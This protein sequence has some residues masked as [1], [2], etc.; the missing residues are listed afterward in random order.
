MLRV[1][2]LQWRQRRREA[3]R[4]P[5]ILRKWYKWQ[6]VDGKHTK[7]FFVP[8]SADTSEVMQIV[9]GCD[10]TL[11]R[12]TSFLGVLPVKRPVSIFLYPDRHS[13]Q[14]CEQIQGTPFPAVMK[15]SNISLPYE[16]WQKITRTMAHELT[17]AV[18]KQHLAKNSTRLLDEALATYVTSKL[19]PFWT[20]PPVPCS[21]LSLRSLT[22]SA[23]FWDCIINHSTCHD[24]YDHAHSFALYLI[25]RAGMN[26]FLE[27]FRNSAHARPEQWE[28]RFAAAVQKTY[29]LSLESLEF[30]WHQNSAISKEGSVLCWDWMLPAAQ[31]A[32]RKA[33]ERAQQQ[34]SNE[35]Q[36]EHLLGAFLDE[37]ESGALCPAF[38]IS[39]TNN[40]L[41]SHR[42]ALPDKGSEEKKQPEWAP[43]TRQ[44]ISLAIDEARSQNCAY[45]G[46]E[47]LLLGALSKKTN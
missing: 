22:N 28:K 5:E 31:I 36:V 40:G 19:Y 17:H 11:Q 42:D 45:I 44:C 38:Q 41:S 27:V 43:A 23:S 35:V 39:P 34:G 4:R 8:P 3:L 32:I 21:H 15:G 10:E 29:G 16:P 24:I 33:R 46:T 1:L 20:R 25:H 30:Q 26:G 6:R 18:S 13:F 47:H 9:C 37:D 14:R 2:P 7:V 12:V